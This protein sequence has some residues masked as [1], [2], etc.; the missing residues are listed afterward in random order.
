MISCPFCGSEPDF[1]KNRFD[2]STLFSLWCSECRVSTRWFKTRELCV[3]AWNLRTAQSL[4]TADPNGVGKYWFY[5]HKA[6]LD[7]GYSDPLEVWIYALQNGTLCIKTWDG[8][9]WPLS[10]FKSVFPDGA[11]CKILP[12]KIPECFLR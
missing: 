2:E 7:R 12:P 3:E 5:C 6:W 10:S 4:W 9:D 11:F 1:E 8:N